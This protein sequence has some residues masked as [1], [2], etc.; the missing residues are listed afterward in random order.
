MR[1]FR[2]RSFLAVLVLAALTCFA[3]SGAFAQSTGKADAG[4][5]IKSA[6]LSKPAANALPTALEVMIDK[7]VPVTL[8]APAASIFIANPDI[9]DV[10]VLSPTSIMVY[11]KK[12]GQTTLKITDEAGKDLA[13]RTVM[14][15]QNL[16]DLREALRAVIPGSNIKVESIPNGIIL[17]GDVSDSSAIEDAR[18][19]A[20]RYV[21][22]DTG[23]IINRIKV[24]AN[25]QVMIRVR[26]AEVSRDVDKR[27]GINWENAATIGS[28]VFALGRGAD[29]LIPGTDETY[30]RTTMS[31]DVND[32]FN[33]SFNN[34]HFS[35]NGM[36]DALAKNGLVTILAEPSLTAMSGETASFLAGG[37]F[38][39]PVPQSADTITIEWKQ[40]GVSLAFTPTIIN[41]NRIN[42]HVRPEVSQLSDS[43]AITLNNIVVPALT[44]RRAETTLELNSGQSFALAGLL[45]NQQT[46]A[47]NKF[48]FLGDMPILGPLFR[49]TRFQNN[50]TEL[51]I[52]ITPYIVKP[53][54]QEQ[55][56]LPTDGFAP[57]T[58]TDFIF[59][60]RE[61]NSDP[62]ARPVSGE[63]RAVHQEDPIAQNSP[64]PQAAPVSTVTV[65]P[66]QTTETPTLNKSAP[67]SK[68]A[69]LSKLKKMAPAGPGGFI[70]E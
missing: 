48:P 18:R 59:K 44:T 22:R 65:V 14:V 24:K 21:P 58:D 25:N 9:A 31:S 10:Q 16:A 12:E 7:S 2:L 35:I 36:V 42:L 43:G 33:T 53:S 50:E 56:A 41:D 27:F 52:I 63:P 60:M 40:Y 11:G 32:A 37:E 64:S 66:A 39:V 26:F 38:P 45:N 70:V 15:S 19:L 69:A 30:T 29:F 49:S 68:P 55:L 20:A 47:V 8:R 46:Q 5:G 1:L 67:M 6:P 3:A 54:T 17:T 57:P 4:K 13:Y 51:V 23:D 61:T 62:D 28:F 34:R